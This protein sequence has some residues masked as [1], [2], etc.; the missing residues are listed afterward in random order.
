M[1]TSGCLRKSIFAAAALLPWLIQLQ[2]TTPATAAAADT[3]SVPKLVAAQATVRMDIDKPGLF[4]TSETSGTANGD[5]LITNQGTSA[6][7]GLSVS[8][9]FRDGTSVDLTATTPEGEAVTDLAVNGDL[10]IDVSLVWRADNPDSGTFVVKDGNASGPPTI[11]FTV[12]EIVPDLS[13]VGR[14]SWLPW[15]FVLSYA[16]L[17]LPPPDQQNRRRPPLSKVVYPVGSWTSRVVGHP[18]SPQWGDPRKQSDR[19]VRL[20]E[21]CP[22]GVGDR[23]VRRRLH[24]V[25]AGCCACRSRLR[26]ITQCDR[27]AHLPRTD[28]CG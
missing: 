22:A 3:P 10:V 28:A 4:D 21:R 9:V 11:P 23:V 25:W 8:G 16:S 15:S 2:T 5:L 20:P 18:V 1:P 24:R 7:T 13:S 12:R 27:E 6:A 26:R 17:K 19:G 14:L